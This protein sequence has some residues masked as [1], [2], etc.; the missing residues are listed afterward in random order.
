MERLQYD[1]YG[2]PAVVHLSPFTLATP[3]RHEVVVRV[4]ATSINPMDWKIRNG[5]FKAMTGSRFP[6][7][8]GTDFAGIV[9]A[10][11]SD[12]DGF[13]R[14]DAVVGAVSLKRSGAFAPKVIASQKHLVK[15][16]RGLSFAEA[17]SLPVAGVTAWSA[18]VKYGHLAPGQCVFI[19]GAMGA[20]GQAA[21]TIAQGIGALVTGRVGPQSIAGAQSLGLVSTLDYSMP[22]PRSLDGTFDVVFDCNGSLSPQEEDRIKRRGGK[23]V[24]IV[25][26]RAKF[27]KA[28][29]SR[30][31]KVLF[32]DL[33]AEHLQA[34]VDLAAA[35][36]L[37]IPVAQ[38]IALSDAPAFL[39]ALE[40]GERL[41]GKAVISFFEEAD[42]CAAA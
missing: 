18:L 41:N 26:S 24:D 29:T 5:D 9:D 42:E 2:G 39:A 15:K 31:R 17:A 11:G 7:A 27:L 40:R 25:P 14:G 3:G 10:V 33:K 8:M 19:N 1:S 30:L 37:R 16:P 35:G 12:V 20:V 36:K 34:V 28:L 38:I 6:R 21:V 13:E 22:L 32:A 23:I 4:A